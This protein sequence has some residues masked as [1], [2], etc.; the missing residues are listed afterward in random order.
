MKKNPSKAAMAFFPS[1][2]GS[3]HGPGD[4]RQRMAFALQGEGRENRPDIRHIAESTA[5]FDGGLEP[6]TSAL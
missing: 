2:E 4:R 6:S 5:R 1:G 3:G